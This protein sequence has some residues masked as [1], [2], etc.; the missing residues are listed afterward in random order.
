M[1]NLLNQ[2]NLI[3]LVIQIVAIVV[4]TL[5]IFRLIRVV[6][7]RLS[8]SIDRKQSDPLQQARLKTILSAGVY[9]LGIVTAIIAVLMLLLVLGI[10]I[11]P[12]IASVGVMSL[13][14][15]LGAQSLI[16]DYIG[17]L[18]ILIEDQ[19]R[20]G[21]QVNI[22]DNIGTVEQITLRYTQLRDLEG[23]L[24][25]VSNGDIRIVTRAGYDWARVIVDINVAF[26]ADIGSVVQ[27]LESAMLRVKDA[28]EISEDLLEVPVIQGWNSTSAWGVQVR[29]SA[30]TKPNRKPDVAALVRRYALEALRE[31]N[32]QVVS[33]L[34]DVLPRES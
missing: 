8:Q 23:R 9:V 6:A 25:Y 19:Y 2:Q 30:K 10:N 14:I 18:L 28:P 22:E 12:V 24:T 3:S 1:V 11:T 21:D 17:G 32:F 4:L 16:K 13:A 27:V 5:V 7:A 29:L 20:V 33:P 26:D 15:S 31:A 34:Q